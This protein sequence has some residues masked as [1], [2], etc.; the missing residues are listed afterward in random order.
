[1]PK[2]KSPEDL[3]VDELRRLLVEKRRATRQQRLDRYRKTGRVV[4]VSS[5]LDTPTLDS[6]R[7]G[8]LEVDDT[9]KPAGPS[10]GKRFLDGFLLLVE[11][12]A[13]VGFIYI[14]FSGINV[15]QELNREVVSVLEQPTLT[16]TPLIGAV[17]LPSGHTPPDSPGGAQFNESEI[18]EHLRPLVQ[19]L[20]NVP[21]PT[22]GPEQAIRIQVPAIGV[23]AP[24]VQGDGWEQLKKG[25]GQHLGTS[26]PGENGNLVLSAH[27]D[28]FGELFRDLDRLNPGDLVIVY[29]NQRSYTYIVVDTKIVEPTAVEVMDQTAQPTT[30]LISCYP[31]LKD[32]KRIV[33]IARLQTSGS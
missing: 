8:E 23:D 17:V 1:V 5:D 21:V 15:I 6:W 20:F 28:I 30:T 19:S 22:P 3:T 33:V 29:T 16:P 10:W 13:V 31:Y 32:N 24:I 26:N 4:M 7:S 11:I 14:L 18:P 12:S 9:T 2:K 25:V 27:N